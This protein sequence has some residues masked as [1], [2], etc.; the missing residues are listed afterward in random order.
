MTQQTFDVSVG[1][2][3]QRLE[4]ALDPESGKTTIRLNGR[5]AARPMLPSDESRDVQIGTDR[6]QLL[7]RGD[8]EF[9][10]EFIGGLEVQTLAQ[11]QAAAKLDAEAMSPSGY[12]PVGKIIAGVVL[13]VV[14]A[15]ALP[16]IKNGLGIGWYQHK[17]A[18]GRFTFQMPEPP[19]A[20]EHMTAG[21]K[22][23]EYIGRSG[24]HEFYVGYVDLPDYMPAEQIGPMI[25]AMRDGLL[26]RYQAVA[27]RDQDTALGSEIV[28]RSEATGD[29]YKFRIILSG[30]RIY[31]LGAAA[32]E[33]EL[34]SMAVM[35]FFINFK[36][37]ANRIVA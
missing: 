4:V 22:V 36:Q 19:A 8:G 7:R 13:L 31:L 23:L 37:L 27:V 12:L 25:N 3:T 18:D 26:K 24:E 6:Y 33:G 15:L 14:I 10:L 5:M 21:L 29:D 11:A 9:E 34:G 30:K 16:A 32:P 1:N 35:R 2:E 28:A 17:S 20:D